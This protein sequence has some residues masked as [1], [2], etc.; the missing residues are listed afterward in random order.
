MESILKIMDYHSSSSLKDQGYGVN[1][2]DQSLW[3][4]IIIHSSLSG[5]GYRVNLHE[6]LGSMIWMNKSIALWFQNLRVME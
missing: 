5:K 4:W 6:N 3:L 1:L 2:K